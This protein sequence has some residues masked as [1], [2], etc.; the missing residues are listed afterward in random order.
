[1][2]KE[3]VYNCRGMCIHTH[4]YV[5][6][7]VYIYTKPMCH[8]ALSHL[9]HPLPSWL[10]MVPSMVVHYSHG[11]TYGNHQNHH[12]K[13]GDLSYESNSIIIDP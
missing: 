13:T 8:M 11:K 3:Y 5:C 9:D 2:Q 12:Q 6:M 4:M 7:Y 1:M 10:I